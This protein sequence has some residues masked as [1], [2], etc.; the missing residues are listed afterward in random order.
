MFVNGNQIN[1]ITTQYLPFP[2]GWQVLLARY[3]IRFVL[4]VLFRVS[5]CVLWFNFVLRPRHELHKYF[6]SCL[7]AISHRKFLNWFINWLR[8]RLI[9]RKY[10][11][12][13]LFSITES[14]PFPNRSISQDLIANYEH[15]VSVSSDSVWSW[16]EFIEQ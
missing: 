2:S 6:D 11:Q 7:I 4:V 3:I 12:I 8:I 14:Y 5:F 9:I 10:L 15:S 1:N 16:S 13:S